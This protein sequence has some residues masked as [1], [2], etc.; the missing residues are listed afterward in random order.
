M[1]KQNVLIGVCA[2]I[3]AYKTCE[4]VR[5]LVK[6][7]H[8]VKVMMTESSAK[9]ITPLTF[10]TLSANPVYTEMF[11]LLNEDNVQHISLAQWAD[12]CLIA[13]ATAN[14]ISKIA[15]GFC[16]NLLTTVVCALPE[17]IPVILAP[18]MNSQMW[19]NPI[20]QE[21]IKKLKSLKK[22]RIIEPGKG[23]LACG[24]YGDGRMAEPEEIFK[25]FKR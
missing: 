20:I 18:A 7:G 14:T 2:G 23:E 6:A 4:L 17:N 15:Y 24:A 9:F 22:Y 25:L 16:D 11:S 12:V 5:L 19:N 8:P 21:N 10:Q 1:K 13:P 3:A